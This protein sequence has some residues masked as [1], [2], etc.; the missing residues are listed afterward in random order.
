[1]ARSGWLVVDCLR[2]ASAPKCDQGLRSGVTIYPRLGFEAAFPSR[3]GPTRKGFLSSVRWRV[4]AMDAM[5]FK[6]RAAGCALR[7][8]SSLGALPGHGAPL[9]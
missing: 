1:M 9:H 6:E 7:F 2:L 8:R 4:F 3:C 5:R